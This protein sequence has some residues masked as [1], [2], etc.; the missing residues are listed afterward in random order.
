MDIKSF[1]DLNREQ[2]ELIEVPVTQVRELI[3]LVEI[4]DVIGEEATM[5]LDNAQ[6]KVFSGQEEYE[7]I[8]I[9]IIKD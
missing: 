1:I 4:N 5:Y 8:I 2:I 9:K 3:D 7:Y 6:G